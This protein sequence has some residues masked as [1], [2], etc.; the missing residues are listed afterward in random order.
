M[1]LAYK[2]ANIEEFEYVY[3]GKCSRISVRKYILSNCSE[4]LNE[5]D[6]FAVK[7]MITLD[8]KCPN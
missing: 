1:E 2:I 5:R 8:H 3:L 7:E 4:L 6:S